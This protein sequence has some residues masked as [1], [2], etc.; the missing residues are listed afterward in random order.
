M[1]DAQRAMH[2]IFEFDFR[3]GFANCR[4]A[5]HIQFARKNGALEANLFQE[6]NALRRGIVHLRAGNQWQRGQVA[7][8][9]PDILNDQAIHARL[10]K[11]MGQSRRLVR[12]PRP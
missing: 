1:R 2:E 12:F 11:M 6:G 10:M 7:F 9:K 3:C 4:D 8:E 5:I